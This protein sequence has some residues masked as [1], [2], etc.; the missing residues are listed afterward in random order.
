MVAV[1][2]SSSVSSSVHCIEDCDGFDMRL[3]NNDLK[4][5]DNNILH[6]GQPHVKEFLYIG[7]THPHCNLLPRYPEQ[8]LIGVQVHD[9]WG[10]AEFLCSSY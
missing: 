7:H 1:E 2:R 10:N 3:L 9:K 8:E 5:L 4:V 6:F